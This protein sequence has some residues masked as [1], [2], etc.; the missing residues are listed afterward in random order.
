M[1]KY[2]TGEIAKLANVSVRTVQYY[3]TRGILVP[4]E[5]TDGGR[6]LYGEEDVKRLRIICFLRDAGVS[7]NTI[8]ELFCEEHPE[9]VISILLEHQEK[10]LRQA[11]DEE[12]KKLAIV[13]TLR[14][15]LK[16]VERLSV[17]SIG[18][19]AYMMKGKNKLT[20]M[21]WMMLLVGIPVT[22]LQWTSIVLW[23]TKGMWWLFLVW[24]AV[25][26]LYGGSVSLYYFRRVAYICPECHEVFKPRLRET[27]FAYHTPTMRRLTCPHCAHNGMCI[28]VY[29]D[30]GEKPNG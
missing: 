1:S 3:D 5:L 23:I 25:G 20:R 15:E 22:A 18:D 29:D 9:R 8:S 27:F 4:S 26:T 21:R 7:I 6:R 17:E 13:E 19:I 12:L 11:I 10:E 14:R 24:L 28:E 30:K 2:T 16:T